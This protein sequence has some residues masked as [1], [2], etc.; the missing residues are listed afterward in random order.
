M[1]NT[2]WK[3]SRPRSTLLVAF[4]TVW[5]VLIFGGLAFSHKYKIA[6]SISYLHAGENHAKTPTTTT[7]LPLP[8]ACVEKLQIPYEIGPKPKFNIAM[9]YA[10]ISRH[11][12]TT[13][14][15]RYMAENLQL[16][17]VDFYDSEQ[18]F[19]FK[20]SKEQYMKVIRD[21]IRDKICSEYDAIFISDSLADGWGFIVG[22]E[23]KCKNVVFVT[24]NRFDIGVQEHQRPQFYED[25]NRA[26]NRQDEYRIKILPNNLFEI[27]FMESR[28]M[29]VPK[30]ARAPLIRPF[31]YTTIGA[32]KEKQKREPCLIIARVDQDRHLMHDLVRD[33]TEFDCKVLEGHY[34]GPR[35]LSEYNSIVVHLPYQVSIMKM[36]ENLAYG[37]LMAIPSPKFFSKICSEHHCGQTA[38]V[39]ETKHVIGEEKWSQFVDFYLPGWEKCFLRFDSWE[40]L[41]K[42]LE[43]RD[44]E[45]LVNYCRDKMVDMR[46][47]NLKEWKDFLM[48]EQKLIADQKAGIKPKIEEEEVNESGENNE[49]KESSEDQKEENNEESKEENKDN[50]NGNQSGNKENENKEGEKEKEGG[51]EKE[52]ENE[53]EKGDKNAENTN[54]ENKEKED[55]EDS[56]KDETKEG[57]KD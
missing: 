26:L 30:L 44:Y 24:T 52:S 19:G 38:D 22:E 9:K 48:A 35:T 21:G 4:V 5:A 37:T 20:T 45:D 33:N 47:Q 7:P 2:N 14:D 41:K 1:L 46:E 16:E 11:I 15:F 29:R 51:S 54:N 10:Y 49:N 39:F 34:G 56:N 13:T 32:K 42:I 50:Q 36:W 31:G 57:K 18:W 25:F 3:F 8:S 53:S 55:A 12:G 28:G 6:E 23:P 17:N 40:N 27:P 43:S